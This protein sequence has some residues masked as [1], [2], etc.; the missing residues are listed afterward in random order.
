M[1][2]RLIAILAL[3]AAL[4]ACTPGASPSPTTNVQGTPEVTETTETTGT[5][6]T[7]GTG[8]EASPSDAMG[9]E[10]SASPS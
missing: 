7:G 6:D 8:G 10:A 4:A 9:G 5:E 3:S 1:T 2:K